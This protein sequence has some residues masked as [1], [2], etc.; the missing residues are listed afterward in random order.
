[1]TNSVLEHVFC[2]CLK[3]ASTP[4]LGG[5]LLNTNE[6]GLDSCSWEHTCEQYRQMGSW[7]LQMSSVIVAK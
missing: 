4:Q 7:K 2:H 6:H 1:M 3:E 5:L